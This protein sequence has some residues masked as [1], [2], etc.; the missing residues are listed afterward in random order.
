MQDLYPCVVSADC[1]MSRIWIVPGLLSSVHVQLDGGGLLNPGYSS[2]TCIHEW[3]WIWARFSRPEQF[4]NTLL[5]RLCYLCFQHRK[6]LQTAPTAEQ[7]SLLGI[8]VSRPVFSKRMNQKSYR[9]Q[10]AILAT[11]FE[12][13]WLKGWILCS[14]R[15]PLRPLDN[16]I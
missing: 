3:K 12:T 14:E 2:L 10:C 11:V 4:L 13:S 7:F 6:P 5:Q 15:W 1:E 9:L 16:G 8:A